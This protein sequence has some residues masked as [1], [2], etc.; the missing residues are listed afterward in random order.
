MAIIVR[1]TPKPAKTTIT[2]PTGSPPGAVVPKSVSKVG[3]FK[4]GGSV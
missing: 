3:M 1:N 2:K 4:G